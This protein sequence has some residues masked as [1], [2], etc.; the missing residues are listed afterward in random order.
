MAHAG[1][2]RQC[3]PLVML[4]E[5]I[6]LSDV[7]LFPR[8]FLS[9]EMKDY[10]VLHDKV[11]ITCIVCYYLVVIVV[12][13]VVVVQLFVKSLYLSRIKGVYYVLVGQYEFS[14]VFFR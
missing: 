13:C 3:L 1:S 10:G 9:A 7:P 14:A 6:E 11:H 4:V 5:S 8:L 2:V 12:S